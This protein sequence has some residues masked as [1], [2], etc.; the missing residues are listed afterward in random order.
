MDNWYEIVEGD[1]LLQ[2]DFVPNC[3]I[4]VPP[5]SLE[6]PDSPERLLDVFAGDVRV[7]TYDV[8]ILSQS[9]DLVER[10][11]DLVLVCPHYPLGALENVDDEVA[12]NFFR[13]R[14]GKEQVRRRESVT[15]G[16]T[17]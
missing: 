13:S 7:R 17:S 3:P 14:K 12:R 10:K 9:C 6:I 1:E 5:T 11:L 16:L 2:G 8:V 15:S 4:I